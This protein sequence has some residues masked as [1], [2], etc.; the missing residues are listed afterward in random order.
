MKSSAWSV[1]TMPKFWIDGVNALG[2]ALEPLQIEADSELEAARFAYAQGCIPTTIRPIRSGFWNRLGRPVGEGRALS[3]EAQAIF[4]EQLAEMLRSG[5]T[6]EQ[7]LQ[8]LSNQDVGGKPAKLADRL[9]GRIREGASLSASLAKETGVS[10][11]FVG[12]LKG[13][14]QGGSLA[15]GLGALA[16]Y[17]ER[18]LEITR[19]ISS[20]L[21][22]PAVVLVV[23]VFA[24]YFILAV[25]MPEFAPIF[26]G[27]E[28]RL[29]AITRGILSLSALVE[30]GMGLI[31]LSMAILAAAIFILI[32]SVA[33]VRRRLSR[34]VLWLPPVKYA[35]RLDLARAIQ[36][37][38]VLLS[39]GVE[40]SEAMRSAAEVSS[41]EVNRL[42]LQRAA[43]QLREGASISAILATL[44]ELPKSASS[45]ISVGEHAGEIGRMVLRAA[46][47]LESD[48][49]RRIDKF[50]AVL[51]PAAVISLGVLIA[52]LI[53]GVMVGI[54]SISQLALR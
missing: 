53:A 30:D 34:A 11:V 37:L 8:V 12:V 15:D 32:R 1:K 21:A 50:L 9:L 38:G 49:N 47:L 40:A 24:I 25:V 45:L 22:Y 42:D 17:L 13:A 23:A 6:L 16:S 27:E 41:R 4:F 48:T 39:N 31:V 5:L 20:A 19:R 36:V 46:Q 33:G 51:N 44:S 2:H 52:G 29:P 18:Q 14:E 28:K 54:L 35:V 10:P 43:V 7:G 26:S 3:T